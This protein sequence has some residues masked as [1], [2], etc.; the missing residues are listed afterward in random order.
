MS[1]EK[2]SPTRFIGIDLHKHY[3][4]ALGVDA[5]LNQVFGP[6]RIS[7]PQLESWIK[8]TI[9]A[10]DA[11][12]VEIT[13]N[14]W[15]VYDELLPYAHSV[16]VVHPP[17]VAL[18][19]RSQVMN[20]R[21][22]AAHLARLHAKGLLVGIWVPPQEVRDRRALLAQRNKMVRLSTQAKNRLHSTLHRLHIE[23]PAEGKPF[24]AHLRPWWEG[25]AVSGI[26]KLR[27]L[28]DLD[29]LD[30]SKGQIERLEKG[31]I[32]LAAA[33]E[34]VPLLIQLPGV[35]LIAAMTILAAI[36]EVSRFP[37]AK[38]LVGYAG[39]GGRVHDSGQTS[40]T[41]R[42]T[43]AGRR[44]LRFVMIE[45]AQRAAET[46]P[47]WKAE[48]ARKEPHLGRNKTIVAIARKLL[49]SVWYVL[50]GQQADR[51]VHPE[52]VARKFLEHAYLLGKARRPDGQSSGAYVRVQLDRLKIGCHL[53][54][55]P[56]G[57]KKKPI[58]LPPSSLKAPAPDLG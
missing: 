32:D 50:S 10:G 34:R 36:G 20:D 9:T 39:L 16:T 47:H 45:A 40:R 58:P 43:K 7:L 55:V 24:S 41:G 12:V 6:R 56:W 30:F 8:N 53:R 35:R 28:S 18:I 44:D 5:E 2:P 11:I 1:L 51:F 26:D 33:D 22:A 13:T 4:V 23:L 38:K 19:T 42:I 49:I 52:K 25:L 31:L 29:T 15:Q 27:I 57:N 37:S 21:I 54:S 3:L 14:T 17:H 48:L 46:H